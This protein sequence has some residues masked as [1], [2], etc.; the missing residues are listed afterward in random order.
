MEGSWCG[1][2]SAREGSANLP[3]HDLHNLSFL[4]HD[5][6]CR[7]DLDPFG[8]GGQ[9]SR[10]YRRPLPLPPRTNANDQLLS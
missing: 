3:T 7:R 1:S 4:D 8:L 6:G 9:I 10:G 5:R 2:S